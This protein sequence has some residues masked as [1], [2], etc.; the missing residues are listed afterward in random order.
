MAIDS[1]PTNLVNM[2]NKEKEIKENTIPVSIQIEDDVIY[3]MTSE[4]PNKR[5]SLTK[6]QIR[7]IF[8]SL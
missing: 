5:F 3:F 1:L 2:M 7:N 4:H 6:A 8:A